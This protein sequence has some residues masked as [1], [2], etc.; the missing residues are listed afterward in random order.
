MGGAGLEARFVDGE[1]IGGYVDSGG[2]VDVRGEGLLSEVRKG[3][4]ETR[5]VKGFYLCVGGI[6]ERFP[7][8]V[9]VC[10]GRNSYK[11]KRGEER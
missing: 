5:D 6:V 4:G 8:F 9:V 3:V 10:I 7:S 2:V 11:T 1:H